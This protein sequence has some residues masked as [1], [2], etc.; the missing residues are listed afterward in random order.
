MD[1]DTT[2]EDEVAS[3]EEAVAASQKEKKASTKTA[4]PE[5]YI[6]PVE[7]AKERTTRT[8]KET[9]PQVVYGYIKNMKEFPVIERGAED[10][11]RFIVKVPEA[12]EFLDAKDKER[13]AKKAEKDAKASEAK[14]A[15]EAKAAETADA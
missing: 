8:G 14:V 5:G 2:P 4:I 10:K 12:H 6:S 13:A 3:E 1:T 11:P 15:E 7:F 9:P